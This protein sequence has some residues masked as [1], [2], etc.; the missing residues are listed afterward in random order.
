MSFFFFYPLAWLGALAIAAPLW[1]HLHRRHESNVVWFSALQ[2]LE[3]Q[4]VAR[5]RP[6]W[7]RDLPLLLLRMLA[8]LLLAA[9]FAWPYL[10]VDDEPPVV[11]E[12]VVYVLD[13]TLSHQAA[14]KLERAREAVAAELRA[15]S[16]GRQTAVVALGALPRVLAD[17]SVAPAAAA[18][19][20]EQLVPSIARGSYLAAMRQADELLKQ[21][22]GA[23]RRIQLFTDN[24]TNQWDEGVDAAPYLVDVQVDVAT[25]DPPPALANLAVWQ[26]RAQRLQLGELALV[27]CVTQIFHQGPAAEAELEWIVNGESI[28]RR[29]VSL[30]GEPQVISV[31]V[32]WEGR[33][34]EW[35][36]GEVRVTGSPD[37]LEADNRAYFS[38]PPL[39]RGTVEAAVQSKF[40][41][42]ALQPEVLRDRWQIRTWAAAANST[43]PTPADVLVVETSQLADEPLRD[44]LLEQLRARRGVL[45][46]I[47][48]IPPPAVRL[49]KDLGLECGEAR[50]LPPDEAQIR[51][52]Y[53]EHPLFFPFQTGEF[54]DLSQL[55]VY[56]FHPVQ[57]EGGVPLMF[58]QDG[59]PLFWQVP[60]AGT[61]LVAGFG[62]DRDYTDWPL[63]TSFVP[64]LDMCLAHARPALPSLEAYQPGETCVWQVPPE[65]TVTVV[66]L[67]DGT[68]TVASA[69]VANG[70][71]RL[72]MPELAGLYAVRYAEGGEPEGMLEVNPSPD[73]SRLT[74]TNPTEV[75]ERW[76]LP[77]TQAEPPMLAT[78]A[79]LRGEASILRQRIWWWLLLGGILMLCGE[80]CWLAWRKERR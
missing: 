78:A 60:A 36:R 5:R 1:L 43:Q 58:A 18:E 74:Y 23:T 71:A 75:I 33:T 28:G 80:T 64:F 17:F 42:A 57:A 16:A 63:L 40:L 14:G 22:L 37:A 52:F 61:L 77:P 55:R 73:E 4:P 35:L 32:E 29:K 19:R 59:E 50:G 65:T 53:G 34:D 20:V 79:P 31:A 47:D 8:V 68:Q 21:S 6:L 67:H 7:P 48:Q 10:P 27:Q 15:A 30:A 72:Q 76:V 56:R 12:S 2:F 26:P 54:G 9:A 45:L 24:Q 13:N 62:L 39:R 46:V 38:L 66:S 41:R 70:A 69:P 25:R 51:Y 11:T 49:L 3:D 44:H